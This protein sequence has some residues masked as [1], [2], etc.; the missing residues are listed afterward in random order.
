M[1]NYR[2]KFYLNYSKHTE[3]SGQ[4]PT[5]Y[6]YSKW[7]KTYT[8]YLKKWLPE[9]KNTPILDIGC[10]SGYFLWMVNKL[11]YINTTGIDLS[12]SQLQHARQACPEAKII[13]DDVIKVL[14]NS[15]SKF[16]LIVGFDVI[17]HLNKEEL[18]RLFDQIEKQLLPGGRVI[19][20]VPNLDSPWGTSIQYGDFTHE[21]AFTPLVLN[22]IMNITGLED[23]QARECGP[24]PH[25]FVS[26]VRFL[27]WKCLRAF[28]IAWNLVELGNM[29]SK[30][31]TRV[32]LGTA[33]KTPR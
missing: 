15:D 25:G 3:M 27:L 5:I 14:E 28:I 18:L 9:D 17:E 16:G 2:D 22:S 7:S 11:G 20:Q 31:F 21:T 10:G 33:R 6:S 30:V 1:E 24:Y 13:C 23:Y 12:E 8:W 29:G 32:F 26:S 4:N 19:F